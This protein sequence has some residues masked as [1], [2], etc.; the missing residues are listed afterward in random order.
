MERTST[1]K[2]IAACLLLTTALGCT[3]NDIQ[4]QNQSTL[5]LKLP[6]SRV[7]AA[8]P[9]FVPVHIIINISGPD[10]A[11][12]V[13][14][15]D[16]ECRDC[17]TPTV[18]A[19][20]VAQTFTVT[21]GPNRLLQLLV[22]FQNME[23]GDMYFAYGDTLTN[24]APGN[25]MVGI[26][27]NTLGTGVSGS[28]SDV[29]GRY[30]KTDGTGPTGIMITEFQPPR[31]NARAMEITRHGIYGGWFRAFALE[32]QGLRQVVRDSSGETVIFESLATNG[33]GL[34]IDGEAVETSGNPNIMK[35]SA[36]DYLQ[37]RGG[38]GG[39]P[40]Y[41]TEN[42][43]SFYLG[44]F[45]P[46]ASG[47]KVCYAET[48]STISNMYQLPI[49]EPGQN[50]VPML[51][52]TTGSDAS[53]V[54]RVGGGVDSSACTGTALV[55]FIDFSQA[56]LGQNKDAVG[57]FSGPFKILPPQAGSTSSPSQIQQTSAGEII[58]IN[59]EYVP[60]STSAPGTPISG[61]TIYS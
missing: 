36:P 40:D 34:L 37:N 23:T 43:Y 7:Q 45:G 15:W 54:R 51:W 38:Y 31:A 13:W 21:S 42:G 1:T 52:N 27:A 16:G 33:D 35:V 5:L 22:V 19:P 39:T 8:A 12:I 46:G 47:K 20:P 30:I 53:A 9:G 6:D 55:D 26:N 61:A 49:P 18:S 44:Y 56:A 17:D 57:G 14:P 32:G 59:W 60:G 58:T 28:D 41:R 2:L 29:M 11:P 10:I 3:R 25:Q 48:P 4:K 24:L 50:P